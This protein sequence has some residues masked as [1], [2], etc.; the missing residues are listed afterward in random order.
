MRIFESKKR[1]VHAIDPF[2]GIWSNAEVLGK[3]KDGAI[4]KVTWPP[5]SSKYDCL[6]PLDSTREPVPDRFINRK[7]KTMLVDIPHGTVV[8]HNNNTKY[9]ID[10]ND[11]FKGEVSNT[12]YKKSLGGF[13]DLISFEI[14]DFL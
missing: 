10:I 3:S 5:Y 14:L 8:V 7:F 6:I 13:F 9:V 1:K 4:V 2:S 12:F 11:P